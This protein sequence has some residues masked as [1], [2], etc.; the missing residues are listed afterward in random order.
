MNVLLVGDIVGRP[1]RTA[2]TK[3]VSQLRDSG[4]VDFVIANAENSASGRGP[5]PEIANAILDAGADVII[6]GD[7]AWDSKEMV[8]GI[9]LEERIIRPANFSKQV[10]GKGWIRVDTPFGKIVVMQFIGRVFM[11]PNQLCPFELADKLLNGELANDKII[12]VDIHAEATSEKMAFG[13]YLDGRVSSVTGTHTHCQ[14]SDARIFKNGT[15]FMTDLGMTG[16]QDSVLGRD[17]DAVTKK[18][19]SGLPVRFP[20][21]ENDVALEGAIVSINKKTGRANSIKSIR[22]KV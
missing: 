7:H 18:L 13:R 17:V 9:D 15:A 5:T 10:P 3:I 21:A 12:F 1:G 2:F 22:I 6:L 11:Q 20:V 14:T 19:I 16:P 8:E 4:Q